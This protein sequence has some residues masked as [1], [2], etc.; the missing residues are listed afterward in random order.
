VSV[1]RGADDTG[2]VA[3]DEQL[4]DRVRD[5]LQSERGLTE[6]RMFG[7]LAF[8]INGNMAASASGQGDLLL[9][10][11]PADTETLIAEPHAQ[12]AVMRGRAMD[13]WLRVDAEAVVSEGDFE[14]WVKRGATYARSLPPK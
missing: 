4:A 14:R 6:K 3:Y 8:L 9:R 10:V 5:V 1:Q 2:L 12:R 13:G 11:D 7:G